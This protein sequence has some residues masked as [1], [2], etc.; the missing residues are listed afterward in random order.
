[1]RLLFTVLS[2]LVLAVIVAWLLQ[3]DPGLLI[4][5]YDE[6]VVQTS[7]AVFVFLS[8]A[9]FLSAYF[10]LRVTGKLLR[11]PKELGRWSLHRRHRRS[12]KCL[13]QGF[14][15][16]I[17]GNW[18][19]AERAFRKGA[20][21]SRLPLVNY[22]GAARAAQL[23]GGADRS[24]HYLQLA[25]EYN[26][27][28]NLAAGITQAEL[29]INQKQIEQAHATLKLLE[30]KQ[31][32]HEQVK[33]MLLD[34]AARLK[35]W[36]QV[37]ALLKE[38]K[39]KG[40]LPLEQIRARQRIA[41]AGLLRAAGR[42]ADRA[43][44]DAFWSDVPDK[45]KKEVQL[46]AAYVTQRLRFADTGDCEVLLRHALKKKWRPELV[47]LYGLVKGDNLNRQLD[48]AEKQLNHHPEDAVLLLTLGRLC[49]RNNLWGK[50]RRY[51][52]RSIDVQPEPEAYQE[53]AALL[54]QQ[55]EHAAAAMYYQEGLNIATSMPRP[56]VETSAEMKTS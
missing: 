15:A 11:F 10:L 32:G 52:E 23:Q 1:V 38:F 24:D 53:L 19:E 40:V 56:D 12:E 39:S 6:W 49:K 8:T 48:H 34:T 54:E 37:I 50:S 25:H 31:P 2:A 26:D 45:L 16:M 13:T 30:S 3:R 29:Q 35:D 42:D 14:L 46:I 18:P 33:L 7:L 27:G 51:L 20:N 9:V 21:Y 44:L 43:A 36:T 4:F 5:A 22:L 41:Y 28:A 17:E 47:R 55:G